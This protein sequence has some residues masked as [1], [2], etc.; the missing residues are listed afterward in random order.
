MRLDDEA[1]RHLR[2]DVAA[3]GFAVVPE[4]LDGATLQ[5]LQTEARALAASALFAEQRET[6]LNYRAHIHPLGPVAEQLLDSAWTH[7]MLTSLFPGRSWALTRERSSFAFY[8][9]GDH[10]D[11][12]LDDPAGRCAV[13][14]IAY[15]ESRPGPASATET[16][17]VLEIYGP[18]RGS[19]PI[20]VIP[21][22]AG[23]VVFGR[24]SKIW[25][26]RPRLSASEY[27]VALTGCYVPA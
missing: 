2:A 13:T 22:H 27:V 19:R 8:A 10:L 20:K 21:T 6:S 18:E 26:G 25:H 9:E 3:F 1:L 17:R 5:E 14:V 11:P 15:V 16:G 23:S 4:A 7:G 24:G 12:H